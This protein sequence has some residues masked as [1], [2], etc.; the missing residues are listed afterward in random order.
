MATELTGWL[1]IDDIPGV[2]N[3]TKLIGT[4]QPVAIPFLGKDVYQLAEG[5]NLVTAQLYFYKVPSIIP[6]R[7]FIV[8]MRRTT[9]ADKTAEDAVHWP[10][11]WPF[12]WLPKLYSAIDFVKEGN[13][14]RGM[15]I[16]MPSG[17]Q[18]LI[19]SRIFKVENAMAEAAA[20]LTYAVD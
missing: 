9:E 6:P 5:V 20:R 4:G 8:G 3:E 7:G 15:T 13:E 16:R 14:Y 12:S 2:G 19:R 1:S 17:S 18:L 10:A 11:D